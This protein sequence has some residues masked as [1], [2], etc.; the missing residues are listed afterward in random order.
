MRDNRP[1]EI[2]LLDQNLFVDG[3]FSEVVKKNFE[4]VAGNL[5]QLQLNLEKLQFSYTNI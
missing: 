5:R 2:D 4:E 1:A 3:E